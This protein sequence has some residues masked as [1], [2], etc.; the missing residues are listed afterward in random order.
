[1]GNEANKSITATLR[2]APNYACLRGGMHSEVAFDA[3]R[4]AKTPMDET[5][6][7]VRR[8]VS[9]GKSAGR[10]PP[11]PE[12]RGRFAQTSAARRQ[13]TNPLTRRAA[14]LGTRV[15]H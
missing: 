14:R 8:C 3:Q 10:V 1:M 11:S 2:S 12:I 15:I 4:P 5:Q 9:A 6:A 7:G 13:W